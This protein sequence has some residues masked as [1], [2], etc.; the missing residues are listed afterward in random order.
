MARPQ[1]FIAFTLTS[2]ALS[3]ASPH[4]TWPRIRNLFAVTGITAAVIQASTTPDNNIYWGAFIPL[5]ANSLSPSELSMALRGSLGQNGVL[6][7]HKIIRDAENAI[8]A[9]LRTGDWAIDS[10]RFSLT[11]ISRG[12][13]TAMIP[14]EIA[15]PG[16]PLYQ[17]IF[18]VPKVGWDT[19]PYP[20]VGNNGH[21]NAWVDLRKNPF[22]DRHEAELAILELNDV[23][24]LAAH[25][26][27][28]IAAQHQD[29]TFNWT[30]EWLRTSREANLDT[31][32]ATLAYGRQ[33]I[34]LVIAAAAI[35]APSHLHRFAQWDPAYAVSIQNK[36]KSA[37]K[38]FFKLGFTAYLLE[39]L[40]QWDLIESMTETE[41]IAL[42]NR[43]ELS[44]GLHHYWLDRGMEAFGGPVNSDYL[45]IV[46]DLL[47]K[48]RLLPEFFVSA[49]QKTF[50]QSQWQDL[51]SDSSTPDFRLRN[52]LG[53]FRLRAM[54]SAA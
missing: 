53:V 5:L 8:F 33:G 1:P 26:A 36:L 4:F 51:L 15:P 9:S 43:L 49:I 27:L 21:T 32:R 42:N 44:E 38:S 14:D 48:S 46:V 31:F 47:S 45:V 22:T 28:L 41:R 34:Q 2:Q 37:E 12:L 10:A 6:F 50:P 54:H 20:T 52:G 23:S 30:H 3:H 39:R 17:F 35:F 24:Q 40:A 7:V 18:A 16:D 13:E 19:F 25:T 11:S 29:D